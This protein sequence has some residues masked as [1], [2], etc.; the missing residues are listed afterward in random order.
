M[1][2]SLS[3]GAIGAAI[4]APADLILIRLQADDTLPKKKRKLYRNFFNAARRIPK[5]EGFMILYN[6]AMPTVIRAMALNF[7]MFCSYE[8]SKERIS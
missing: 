6:G 4:G 5:E 3:S 1:F 7:G 2:A 8:E